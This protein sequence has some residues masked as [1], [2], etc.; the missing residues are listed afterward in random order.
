LVFLNLPSREEAQKHE[1]VLPTKLIPI[2]V[3]FENAEMEFLFERLKG[4]E[5]WPP[6]YPE[7]LEGKMKPGELLAERKK[8]WQK[9]E[10]SYSPRRSM[11]AVEQAAKGK[12][13]IRWITYRVPLTKEGDTLHLSISPAQKYDTGTFVYTLIRHGYEHGLRLVGTLRS[14]PSMNVLAIYEK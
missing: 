2:T 11:M 5:E 3:E 13:R 7:D 9:Y 1:E 6:I 14:E 10:E 4:D 12:G 8:Y